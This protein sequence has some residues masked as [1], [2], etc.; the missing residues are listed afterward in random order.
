LFVS[1][2][3]IFKTIHAGRERGVRRGDDSFTTLNPGQRLSS[4]EKSDR[5]LPMPVRVGGREGLLAK[6][7]HYGPK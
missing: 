4:A 1:S 5:P 2:T 3:S 6:R 7:K